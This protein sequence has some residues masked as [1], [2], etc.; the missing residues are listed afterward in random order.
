MIIDEDREISIGSDHN[1]FILAL[2]KPTP[3]AQSPPKKEKSLK[4]WNIK[5]ETNWDNFR[6]VMDNSFIGWN[7][8]DYSN[9]DD[10][11]EE[12][13]SKIINTGEKC[14][15][16]R[17]YHSKRAFWDKEIHSMIQDRKKASRLYRIWSKHSN[18][19]PELLHLLWEDYL[20]KKQRVAI[21]VKQKV[22]A[23]KIKV[24]TANASK[25]TTNPRA[26][27]NMLKKLNTA[28]DYPIKIQDPNNPDIT[29]DDPCIIRKTLSDYWSKLGNVNRD[30]GSHLHTNLDELGSRHPRPGS[31]STIAIDETHIKKA[32]AKLKNG[33]AMGTDAIPAE[34]I[35][36]GGCILITAL[37]QMLQKIQLLER[38]PEQWYEGVIK[39]LFKEGNKES[40]SNYRGIT[41]S[42]TCYKILVSIIEH[43]VSY[44]AESNNLFN[45]G[46]GAFRKNRRCEDNIL[47]LKGICTIRKAKKQQTFL[48]FLDVSKAFDSLNRD[49][50][51]NHIWQKGL[52]GKCWRLIKM[53]YNKVDS[54]VIFGDISTEFFSIEN[55]VKQGCIL[56]PT[57][58]N[59]VIE[60]LN[61]MLN[62]CLGIPVG[63]RCIRGLY[64]ADDVVLLASSDKDLQQ[65]L[66]IAGHFGSKWGLK[67]N[68][69]KSQVMVIGKRVSNREWYLGYQVLK[70]TKSYKYLG[71]IINR[72]ISETHHIND[73]LKTKASKLQAYMR[74]TLGRHHD[75][76]RVQFGSSLWEKAIS[77]SLTHACGVWFCNTETSKKIIRSMQYKFAKAVMKI[78]AM[79]SASAILSELGWLPILDI[80]DMKIINYFNYVCTLPESRLVKCVLRE[81]II[82]ED[83]NVDTKFSYV[84]H[85]KQLLNEKGLDHLFEV[86]IEGNDSSL[87]NTY[88][89]FTL[90]SYR[91]TFH[92]QLL[93]SS[94]L[95]H[96]QAVKENTFT[97]GYIESKVH[98]F[99]W[100]Q[101]K[102]RLRTGI[103]S[104][105]ED[106][107]RQ[108]RGQGLCKFCGNFESLKHF[109]L[110]C[111]AYILPRSN[112]FHNLKMVYDP[113]TFSA[114]ISDQTFAMYC[115]LGD[116]DD[117]F[118]RCF[119]EYLSSAWA[120]RESVL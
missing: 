4:Q 14:I 24:I 83:E 68:N 26:Y 64:Y 80:M 36:H 28:N 92:D 42:S 100:I 75:L 91:N 30:S 61:D 22:M 99:K 69:K 71:V 107:K 39:P 78:S 96:F 101:L 19:S 53:L 13:K 2:N 34:F 60:D 33:K 117:N 114:F 41:I 17:Q 102:F 49:V 67:F 12:F 103:S 48:A 47:S 55:G 50:L 70:E 54:K 79:P 108:N 25:A 38:M 93:N 109:M 86:I 23:R 81:L 112:M 20:E 85:V 45:E 76:N 56:S 98:N 57:L 29:I 63:D 90:Q 110:Q 84:K 16:Y 89:Q 9:I 40:L 32:I 62:N 105:G 43:Q 119:I 11:W 35:K 18:C 115:L 111:N 5:Q 37:L 106:I 10:M 31:L 113:E 116:H 87:H 3:N 51:F 44:Y 118:N 66:D 94:S 58:F 97:P 46:Q 104:L 59:M 65:M 8:N 74:Y 82:T 95:K 88:K 1:V 15:G 52:Q 7:V 21:N 72:N 6:M 27:W 77:P 73:H 120:I